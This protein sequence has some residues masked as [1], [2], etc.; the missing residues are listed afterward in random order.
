V[1]TSS[2]HQIVVGRVT[3]VKAEASEDIKCTASRA[4][5]QATAEVEDLSWGTGSIS[6]ART[7]DENI[8]C[9]AKRRAGF[10]DKARISIRRHNRNGW[11]A[12]LEV[13]VLVFEIMIIRTGIIVAIEGNG[14][15]EK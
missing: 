7:I 9:D 4:D 3:A 10:N 6:N 12:T 15:L 14:C 2:V 8:S 1:E 13:E 5:I 11:S